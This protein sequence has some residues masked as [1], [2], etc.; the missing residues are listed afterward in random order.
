M[1][2]Y[3]HCIN[4]CKER[5]HS[6][7]VNEA[8][9]RKLITYKT[10]EN[11]RE[12]NKVVLMHYLNIDVDGDTKRIKHYQPVIEELEREL[13]KT[14]Q[15]DSTINEQMEFCTTFFSNLVG[16]YQSGDLILKR[17]IIG[18][19]YPEKFVFKENAI[20]TMR[21]HADIPLICRTGAGFDGD[22]NKMPSKNGGHSNVV[23]RIGFKPEAFDP[24]HSLQIDP[25]FQWAFFTIQ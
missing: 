23:N 4:G 11:A 13:A 5:F 25:I 2:Y 20:Q 15:S 8:F 7:E 14:S 21:L 24:W 19:I 3:Y 17:Q 22:K 18:L 12:Y 6:K 10:N 9:D 1:Y 16:F